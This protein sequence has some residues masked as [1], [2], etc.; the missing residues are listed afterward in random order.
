MARKLDIPG[1]SRM[2]REQLVEAVA[3]ARQKAKR[4]S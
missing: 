1:R 2:K 4:A 3:D